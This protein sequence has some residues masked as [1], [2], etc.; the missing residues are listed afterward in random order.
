MSRKPPIRRKGTRRRPDPAL[1]GVE[2]VFWFVLALA[3]GIGGNRAVSGMPVLAAML[4][5]AG[6]MAAEAE[7]DPGARHVD[8]PIT[9]VDNGK[10][11]SPQVL[12]A[13][14]GYPQWLLA[15]I[16]WARTGG[17]T[18]SDAAAPVTPAVAVV[19]DD[20]GADEVDTRRAIALPKEVS[21]SFLP[22][23]AASPAL[24]QAGLRA[25]HQILVHVPMEPDG[26]T[27]PG[28]MALLTTFGA[29]ENI[30]RLDWALARIP[31]YA[32]INNHEGSRFTADRTALVPVIE[33][34]ADK[35]VFFL[36][37]R[38]SPNTQV[39]PLARAFGVASA[40]RDVFLDDVQTADAINA[41]LAQAENLARSQGVAIAIGHPH[42]VTMD[43]L[44]K[45]TA[46]AAARGIE[47]ITASEA[48]RRKTEREAIKGALTD[49][50]SPAR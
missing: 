31:G 19:I 7:P 26:K 46:D 40:G 44:A 42:A 39:V 27:D 47:L 32:G 5:P 33:H 34:L 45:W 11:Y 22:Y 1:R 48:I 4:M 41:E 9:I 14:P 25:G 8:F 50:L 3:I 10:P 15:R 49:S 24:A 43:V 2:A 20:L 38:T 23:P 17:V 36:D 12:S 35:H 29:A 16:A 30:E 6:E 18:E 21:L 13:G 28:P 37:S